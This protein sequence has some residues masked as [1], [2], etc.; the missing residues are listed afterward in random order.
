VTLAELPADLTQ[1]RL[2]AVFGKYQ[3]HV[4]G[5]GGGDTG[6]H[7]YRVEMMH[8]EDIEQRQAHR[9]PARECRPRRDR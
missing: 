7:Q 5:V 8:R 1:G 9:E 3:R 6:G 4:T 2:L